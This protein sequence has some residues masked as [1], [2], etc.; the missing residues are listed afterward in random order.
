MVA[1]VTYYVKKET[2]HN[3]SEAS[4]LTKFIFPMHMLE[5]EIAWELCEENAKE[6]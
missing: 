5:R 6:S 3:Q 4:I 1:M 2:A